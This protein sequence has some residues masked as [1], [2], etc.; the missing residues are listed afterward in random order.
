M[1]MSRAIPAGGTTSSSISVDLK[2]PLHQY[3]EEG[4]DMTMPLS[5]RSMTDIP[6]RGKRLFIRE[7]FNVPL[8]KQGHITDDTRIKA[9]LPTIRYASEG[10]AKV[11]LASHLG[12]PSR[13][14]WPRCV[15][16][17]CC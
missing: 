5:K 14:W 4:Q 11:I 10:G 15:R 13:R 7:D 1:T 9:A 12:R 3:T 6:L 8:D 17:T 2:Y 16:G